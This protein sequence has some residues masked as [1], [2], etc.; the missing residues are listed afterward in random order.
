[1]L[2]PDLAYWQ[3]VNI[4]T[5]LMPPDLNTSGLGV[6]LEPMRAGDAWTR[7]FAGSG[8]G[9]A[10]PHPHPTPAVVWAHG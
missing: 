9:G 6:T 3:H 10:A 8:S 7:V 2:F 4:A 5:G 1:M